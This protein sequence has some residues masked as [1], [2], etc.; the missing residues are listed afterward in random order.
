MQAVKTKAMRILLEMLPVNVLQRWTGYVRGGCSPV[1][2]KKLYPTFI[3]QTASHLDNMAVSAGRIGMQ[4][5]LRPGE[6][7]LCTGASFAD[8]TRL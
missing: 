1:G 2:M 4:I 5:E 7:A 3:D 8:L 6:L